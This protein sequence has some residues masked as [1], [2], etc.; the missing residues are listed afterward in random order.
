MVREDLHGAQFNKKKK[1]YKIVKAQTGGRGEGYLGA[2]SVFEEEAE[3]EPVFKVE[4][5]PAALKSKKANEEKKKGSRQLAAKKKENQEEVEI[6]GYKLG[7]FMKYL[8]II[9]IVLVVLTVVFSQVM[10]Y[11]SRD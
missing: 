5:A 2:Q 7:N 10:E 6:K 8:I 1:G 3:R 4:A 11:Q 9:A